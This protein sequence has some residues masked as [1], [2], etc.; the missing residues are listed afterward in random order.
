MKLHD[1]L[2]LLGFSDL[3]LVT[4]S[5]LRSAIILI[6]GAESLNSA[7]RDTLIALHQEGPLWDGDIP[8]K[9]GRTGLI[10]KGFAVRIVVRGEQGHN[11]C[12]LSG[13]C[14]FKLIRDHQRLDG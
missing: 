10:E 7:E 4:D 9:S 2:G 6:M 13:S 3:N 8:S 5:E 12:T 1:S 11:A 14:A